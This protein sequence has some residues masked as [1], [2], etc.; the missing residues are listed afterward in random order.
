[1]QNNTIKI[2]GNGNIVIQDSNNSCITINAND[3]DVFEKIQQLSNEQIAA[4]QQI[5]NEQADKFSELFKTLINGV[6]SQK[7][8]VHGNITAKSV[9]IGDEIHYHYAETKLPKELTAKIPCLD[10]DK[11]IGRTNELDELH[12]MLHNNKQV[13]VMNGLG[14]I[15]KTTLAQVYASKYWD[16]YKHIA[17]ITQTTDNVQLDF[18]NEQALFHNLAIGKEFTDANAIFNEVVRKLKAVEQQPNLLI[19]DNADA[20][21]EKLRDKLP[22]QPQ[23]H[24]LITSRQELNGF[25]L[26]RLDFLSPED[27]LRLFKTH[28]TRNKLSDEQINELIK[29]VDLHTLTIEILAKTAMKQRYDFDT[30]KKAI[31]LDIKANIN[32]ARPDADKIERITSY[33]SSIFSLSN[34]NENER[35]LMKQF[36]CLPPEFHTYR[37]LNELIVEDNEKG[38]IFAE[39]IEELCQ[40]GW[41][42]KNEEA[43]SYK[44]HRIIKEVVKKQLP[45]TITESSYLLKMI[46]NKL[47]FDQTKDNPVEK[48]QW[49]PFGNEL[50]GIFEIHESN[51]VDEG[52]KI[53]ILQNNL[54]ILLQELG[55]YKG[56]KELL[57]KA[58]ICVEK[59]FGIEHPCTAINYSNLASV[60]NALGEYEGAKN[61]LEKAILIDEKTYGTEHPS[62]ASKYS[63]LAIVYKSLGDFEKA[64]S[65]LKSAVLS[66]EKNFGKNHPTTSRSYS[67]LATVFQCLG[68]YKRAIELL[69]KAMISNENSFGDE[70]S[71]V[72][73]NYNN[74][75]MV[76][77]EIGKYKEAHELLIKAMNINEKNFGITHPNTNTICSN[78]ALVLI[79]LGDYK[80]AKELLIK[81]VKNS[82]ENLGEEHP[83]TAKFYS[84]LAL[85]LQELGDHKGAKKLLEKTL[86]CYEK[87]L[88]MEHSDTARIYSNLALV[89]QDLGDYKRAIELIIKAVNSDEKN[90]GIEHPSTAIKYSNLAL[91]LRNLGDYNK[92]LELSNKAVAVFQKVLPTGHP[93]IKIVKEVNDYIKQKIK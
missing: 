2:E 60:S 80:S 7:N 61:L 52:N 44:M 3:T 27:A 54:A 82:E 5:I 75:A 49:I 51:T 34:L 74:L 29:S 10:A 86:K 38:E 4:L 50:L 9:S 83:D 30:L 11:I 63:N 65:L 64:E 72:A 93:T 78:L 66:N 57:E 48:F 41:L 17:W 23:W 59:N 62:T 45:I 13:V 46:T 21:L 56:A 19:I 16:D 18:A 85:V 84:N 20:S 28:Y 70:H 71:C 36:V 37:L 43:D 1:M 67:N 91:F 89:L 33:L 40:K 55:N 32:I 79:D 69:E 15:G 87:N 12:Q 81:T 68:N 22:H 53:S 8:V 76:L 31:P 47:D 35:W 25:T 42:L 14:G 90:F 77:K 58:M 6:A 92:A 24:I 73:V 88:G 39:T 26:K